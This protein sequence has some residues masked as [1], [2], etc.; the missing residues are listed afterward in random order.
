MW[1]AGQEISLRS[2]AQ[3]FRVREANHLAKRQ[4]RVARYESGG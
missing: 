4:V 1:S 2:R 3:P